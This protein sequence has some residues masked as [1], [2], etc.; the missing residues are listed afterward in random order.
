MS[1]DE[2]LRISEAARRLGVSINTLRR[3]DAKGILTAQR[4]PT[5]GHRLYSL[6]AL[7][8]WEASSSGLPEPLF[9]RE[10]ALAW[11]ERCRADGVRT[12]TLAGPPG[13]GKTVL[14]RAFA[15]RTGAR[16]ADCSASALRTRAELSRAVARTLHTPR[17]AAHAIVEQLSNE[18]IAM[19]LLDD[20]GPVE[21]DGLRWLDEISARVVVLVTTRWPLALAREHVLRLGPLAYPRAGVRDDDAPA[22]AFAIAR[23]QAHGLPRI[24]DRLRV[25]ATEMARRVEGHPLAIDRAAARAATLGTARVRQELESNPIPGGSNLETTLLDS[26]EGLEE[27][28]RTLMAVLGRLPG[29]LDLADIELLADGP[30]V[31]PLQTLVERSLVQAHQV[32]DAPTT[33]RYSVHAIIR[34][35]AERAFPS[36]GNDPLDGRIARWAVALARAHLD[37]RSTLSLAMVERSAGVLVHAWR[38]MASEED[39]ADDAATIAAGLATLVSVRG[40]TP[41]LIEVMAHSVESTADPGLRSELVRQLALTNLESS[42]TQGAIERLE[43]AIDL[44]RDHPEQASLALAQLSGLMARLGDLDTAAR[45]LD[46]ATKLAD[47][48][49]HA[50]LLVSGVRAFIALLTGR[51]QQARREIERYRSLAIQIGDVAFEA[52]ASS[53]LGNLADD[54][55]RY[56]EAA[57]HYARALELALDP[58]YERVFSAPIVAHFVGHRAVSLWQMGERD[59]ALTLCEEAI[60]RARA[61]QSVRFEAFFEAW[62]GVMLATKGRLREAE[63]A[64]DIAAANSSLVEPVAEVL[65][66][67][68]DLAGSAPGDWRAWARAARRWTSSS[69]ATATQSRHLRLARRSVET[70]LLDRLPEESGDPTLMVSWDGLA[71]EPTRE[72]DYSK[73]PSLRRLLLELVLARLAEPGT[74]IPVASLLGAGWPDEKLV[75]GSGARRVHVALSTLRTQLLGD[76][77]ESVDGAYRLSPNL[78]VAVWRGAQRTQS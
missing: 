45:H 44:A 28:E 2:W 65:R 20:V 14:A 36:S 38:S 34:A 10:D 11:L 30:V 54:Q 70:L 53:H 64:M 59:T 5:S 22:V 58:R 56:D 8:L 75:D 24:D 74:T 25:D 19:L 66:A 40:P 69:S 48:Q 73:R 13:I 7:R 62:R 72:V 23:L 4:D 6:A 71:S 31:D 60:Q 68:V 49:P 77:L 50:T 26:L 39:H 1:S 35:V 41:E 78:S 18:N 76:F 17:C 37:S 15:A 51:A 63:Q 3:W 57:V 67:H 16:V 47:G 33:V 61:A 12:I 52:S 32:P 46:T 42:D 9:G 55:E 21:P 27:Q 29:E 43:H